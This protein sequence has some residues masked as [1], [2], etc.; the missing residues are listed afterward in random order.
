MSE[1]NS[2]A[3]CC[4][5]IALCFYCVALEVPLHISC[6]FH[7][8]MFVP[9]VLFFSPPLRLQVTLDISCKFHS[10]VFR[11]DVLSCTVHINEG[12][13]IILCENWMLFLIQSVKKKYLWGTSNCYKANWLQRNHYNAKNFDC[14]LPC[15]LFI[16]IQA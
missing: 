5:P 14:I 8:L 9:L 15:L 7:T 6:K 3:W 16:R 13:I 12:S 1:T 10:L 11:S 4:L 2:T